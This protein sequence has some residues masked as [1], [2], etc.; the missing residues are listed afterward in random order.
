MFKFLP[1]MLLKYIAYYAQIML[2]NQLFIRVVAMGECCI[3]E[4]ALVP[5]LR[6]GTI[7]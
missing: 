4:L 3:R 1:I 7:V 2:E 6:A 5:A